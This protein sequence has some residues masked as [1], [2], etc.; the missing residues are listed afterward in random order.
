LSGHN[1]D[2]RELLAQEK[3]GH[4]GAT[5]ALDVFCRRIRHYIGAYITEL[6]G[7]DA[8]VFGGGIGENSPDIRQRILGHFR[9][10]GIQLDEVAN[11]ACRGVAASVAASTS[12]AAIE[13]VPVSEAM[14]M[15][16]EAA[17]LLGA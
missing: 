8:I 1:A 10:V 3:I 11:A 14:V 7:V 12:T 6:Q 2:V 9:W 17:A 15:A 4:A 5:L 13:V 16:V